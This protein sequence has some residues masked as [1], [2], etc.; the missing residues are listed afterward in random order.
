MT[1]AQRRTALVI[2]W[3]LVVVVLVVAAAWEAS[4]LLIGGGAGYRSPDYDLL[5]WPGMRTW[6][7]LLAAL[8]VVLLV[9]LRRW[10]TVGQPWP[11]RWALAGLGAWWLVWAAGIVLAWVGQ[12]EI[13]GWGEPA[14]RLVLAVLAIAAARALPR[15]PGGR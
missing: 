11:L 10:T 2:S 4:G 1:S 7:G 13:H 15:L 14:G 8:L 5:H 9:G 3:R 12:R 6:G